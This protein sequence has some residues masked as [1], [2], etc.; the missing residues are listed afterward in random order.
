MRRWRVNEEF[1]G[2]MDRWC[3]SSLR[4]TRFI[5]ARYGPIAA[6]RLA[7]FIGADKSD[8][9][10]RAALDMIDRCLACKGTPA[11]QKD[12]EEAS[13]GISE[14]QARSMVLALAEGLKK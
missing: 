8:T 7:E 4:E 9:A 1:A 12:E 13:G 3:E 14:E 11:P 6:L 10:R 5:M 2:E